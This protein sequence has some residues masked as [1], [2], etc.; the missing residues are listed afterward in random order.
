M[1]NSQFLILIRG[2]PA[3]EYDRRLRIGIENWELSIGPICLCV[4]VFV[5]SSK[6]RLFTS[7]ADTLECFID[8]FE[9]H[10]IIDCGGQFV[11]L[12]FG[13]LLHGA[14]KDFS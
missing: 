13:D 9:C 3:A 5:A 11:L 10:W 7:V 12:A 4:S 14:S 8:L 1:L 2:A 6:Q